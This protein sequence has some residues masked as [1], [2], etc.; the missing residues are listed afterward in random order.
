MGNIIISLATVINM[1]LNLYLIVV[2]ASALISWVSP[3]PNNPIVRFL[4]SATIPVYYKIRRSLPFPLI[5]GGM[6]IT[7]LVVIGII[8]FLEYALVANLIRFGQSLL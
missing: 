4:H 5:F 2:I 8:Y 1:F 3:D 6:D 7:P